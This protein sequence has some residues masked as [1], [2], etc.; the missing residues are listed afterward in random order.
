MR[1]IPPNDCPQATALGTS[2][3]NAALQQSWLPPCEDLQLSGFTALPL[4]FAI[5]E[6]GSE[7]VFGEAVKR[8]S[9]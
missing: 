1:L 3:N 6:E 4:G 8:A 9:P 7:T 2:T 5:I